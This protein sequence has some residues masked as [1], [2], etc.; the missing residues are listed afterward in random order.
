MA[1]G[2]LEEAKYH[3]ILSRDLGYLKTLDFE[4]LNALAD[5]VGRMLHGFRES[6]VQA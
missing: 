4:R 1:E 5:E 3:L 2:S 6:I